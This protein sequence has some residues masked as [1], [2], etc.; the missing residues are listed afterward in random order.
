MKTEQNQWVAG[1]GWSTPFNLGS[2][3]DLVL[4]FGGID[5]IPQSSVYEELRK[6]YPKAR[7]VMATTAGEIIED[8]VA[9]NTI[10]ATAIAFDK[11]D[12]D[13]IALDITD[14]ET[15]YSCGQAIQQRLNRAGLSHMLVISEGT[16]TNGDELVRGIN[17]DLPAGVLV[18]GGLAA[19]AG[20]FSQTYV[21]LDEVARPNRIVAIGF[22]GD[23]LRVGHGSQGGWDP[24]GPVRLVTR[25]EGNVLFELDGSNALDLYKTY[26]GERAADLPGSALLFPLCIL[27]DD[28][29]LVR[30]ILAIDHEKGSMTFAGDIPQGSKVQ[31]MMSNFDRLIDGATNAA[32]QNAN[33]LRDST[34]ELVL[35]ISCVGRKIV[36]HQRIEEEVES[37]VDIFGKGPA[38]C[39]FYSNG[40]ISPVLDGVACSLHN[41][42]M[43]ITT[44]C[45]V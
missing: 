27:G 16:S 38:Y 31:F 33:R 40:E 44:Y 15:S 39:G 20:R 19:D 32:S 36:L 12:V 13:L 37:V 35:M 5:E 3:A 24:F 43:T 28:G 22:Y 42:T 18:T 41:Q 34:P 30:T 7:I 8:K 6:H 25:S 10:V 21:G 23:S 11:T 17:K 14:F 26:L 9:D 1:I 2:H 4:A 29:S 45:E